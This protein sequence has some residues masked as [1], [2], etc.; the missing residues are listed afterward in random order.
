MN[1]FLLLLIAF[2]L[3]SCCAFAYTAWRQRRLLRQWTRATEEAIEKD[4]PFV[5]TPKTT[6]PWW[7]NRNL[8]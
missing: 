8:H 5:T 3:G 4:A 1:A 2:L 7:I 6:H